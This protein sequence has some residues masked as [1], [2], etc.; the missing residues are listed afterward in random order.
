MTTTLID[1]TPGD[2]PQLGGVTHRFASVDGVRIHYA[3]AGRGEPLVLL[4]GWPQHWWSWRELIGPL[5]ERYRVIC[6]DIRGMGWSDAPPSGY[7]LWDLTREFF[8]L[9][10]A[11]DLQRV[12]LVGHDW[13]LLIGYQACFES[14]ERFERFA[15]MGGVHPWTATGS[16]PRNYARPWH[17]Y[18]LATPAGRVLVERTGIVRF[19]LDYWRGGDAF[20]D[21]TAEVYARRVR[22]PEGA[23]A[24]H[25]RDLSIVVREIP[26]F[27]RNHRR[28]RLRVPTLHLNGVRDPLTRG[29][30][31]SWRRFADDMR[32]ELV[33]DSGHFMPE[34]NPAWVAERLG[35]FMR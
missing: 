5:A 26:Y 23:N 19:L 20:D 35:R 11:L 14:P 28:L 3:E 33:P 9:L 34:Q 32:L 16:G 1:A 29:T 17:V 2:M 6:P 12:R 22:R 30:P 10:D 31:D 4:H 7:S 18:L 13:G 24:T 21:A 15:P 25:K 8:G 27:L